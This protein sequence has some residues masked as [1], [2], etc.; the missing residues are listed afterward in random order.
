MVKSDLKKTKIPKMKKH[1]DIKTKLVPDI[2]EKITTA[3]YTITVERDIQ[4]GYQFRTASGISV[5]IY[6]SGKITVSG[7]NAEEL[8]KL[9]K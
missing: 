2:K 4:Y 3:G 9:L 6:T 7:D 8:R 1:I 5:N